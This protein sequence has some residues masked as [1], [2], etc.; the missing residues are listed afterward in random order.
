MERKSLGRGLNDISD[1]FLSELEREDVRGYQE[2]LSEISSIAEPAEPNENCY[3]CTNFIEKFSDPKC[4]IFTFQNETYAVPYME[5]ITPSQGKYCKYFDPTH[6]RKTD[7]LLNK[8]NKIFG[9]T[10][11]QYEVEERIKVARKIAYPDAESSQ[12]RLKKFLVEHLKEGYQIK[13]CKLIKTDN[14]STIGKKESREVEVTICTKE[15]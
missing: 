15:T 1:I 3:Y 7:R 5:K 13:S 14:I 2:T 6:T 12:K 4:K 11:T 10:D 9:P 8:Q